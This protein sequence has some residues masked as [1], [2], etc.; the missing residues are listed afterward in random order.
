[1]KIGQSQGIAQ[2]I[3]TNLDKNKAEEKKALENIARERAL[4]ATDGA[5]LMIADALLSEANTMSQGI[6]NANDAIGM[7][8]I[9]DGVLGSV[10][11][12]A[13][14]LNE[15]SVA[16]GNPMLN[17]SQRSMIEGEANALTQGMRDAMNEASFNGKN[18]FGGTLSFAISN[19]SSVNMTLNAPKVDGISVHNQE[20]ISDFL[21]RVG[22]ERA[23]I[24]A[25]ISGIQSSINEEMNR[26][27]NL[28][29]AESNLQDNDVAENYNKVNKTRLREQAA[30]YAHSF[31]T[32]HLQSKLGALLG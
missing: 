25:T 6:R 1:M 14:R 26:V 2:N 7:L 13:I 30:L 10:T 18:V 9:A 20:S 19:N 24:G 5:N 28:R 23:N 11:D 15:L 22:S 17:R 32:K 4:H 8:Q 27:V 12:S 31:N 16:M 21:K 3:S 29:S